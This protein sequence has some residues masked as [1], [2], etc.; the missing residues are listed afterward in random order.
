LREF[1]ICLG[2]LDGQN[3]EFLFLDNPI[4]KK[5]IIRIGES[6][7]NANPNTF[8]SHIKLCIEDRL[9]KIADKEVS[10]QRSDYLESEIFK[11][12][13]ARI[14]DAWAQQNFKWK[15]GGT[16][17]ENDLVAIIDSHL[18]IFECK[19]HKIH[20]AASRG[21]PKKIENTIDDI[22][23]DSAIQSWRLKNKL[24]NIIS[25][26][27]ADKQFEE[28]LPKPINEIYKITRVSLTLDDFI[29]TSADYA[30][31]ITT[32]WIPPEFK[33]CP[34]ISI[35]DFQLLID[36]LENPIHL[37]HYFER[38]SEISENSIMQ[39]DEMDFLGL[40]LQ[41]LLNHDNIP[42]FDY[43]KININGMSSH[44]LKYFESAD[45]GVSLKKPS[46]L[47]SKLFEGIIHQLTQKKSP[48][49]TEIGCLL[50][51][52]L[53]ND[54]IKIEKKIAELVKIVRKTWR[55]ETHKNSLCYVPPQYGNKGFCYVICTDETW[56][57]R[58]SYIESAKNIVFETERVEICIVA[59]KNIDKIDT[60]YDY[61]Q[62]SSRSDFN[63]AK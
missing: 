48:R 61:L 41:T 30:D 60:A 3:I 11:L 56:K 21:A 59:V 53:P 17:Y 62:V 9:R 4:W 51:G 22:I 13:Q 54:Q 26:I 43:G 34:N 20:E 5:P 31:L 10:D 44:V 18:L 45:A 16:Q 40:Y 55:N 49:W 27:D 39:G 32:G 14:P 37:I 47:I 50:C 52:F 1:S 24:L 38:R 36:V 58:Y 23:T 57:N 7:H 6:F 46:P 15:E 35:S 12:I 2:D 8:F 19:S 42:I 25:G 29:L 28:L 33:P 63:L